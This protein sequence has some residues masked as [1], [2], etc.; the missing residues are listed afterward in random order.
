MKTGVVDA[1]EFDC[2][3]AA[4]GPVEASFVGDK[5][6]VWQMWNTGAVEAAE[7]AAAAALVG[8]VGSSD[9]IPTD[10][11]GCC[12][13]PR[14][15]SAVKAAEVAA[16]FGLCGKRIAAGLLGIP[17]KRSARPVRRCIC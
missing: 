11:S 6:T 1:G 13:E 15:R 5:E 8:P 3:S 17:S 2:N 4:P 10:N 7:E 16:D 12:R 14:L 9:H